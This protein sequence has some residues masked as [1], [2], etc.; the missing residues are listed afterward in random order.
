MVTAHAILAERSLGAWSLRKV[1]FPV[2]TE[3]FQCWGLEVEQSLAFL[4]NTSSPRPHAPSAYPRHLG[5]KER[6]V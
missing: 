1:S 6:G 4:I 3:S 5:R 2:V